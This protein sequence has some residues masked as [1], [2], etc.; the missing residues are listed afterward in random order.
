[1]LCFTDDDKLRPS[2][3]A[4]DKG[5]LEL[6]LVITSRPFVLGTCRYAQS[7]LNSTSVIQMLA[8]NTTENVEVQ[9]S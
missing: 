9:R 6:K 4:R 8:A 2:L 1:M 5:D 3:T 7:T